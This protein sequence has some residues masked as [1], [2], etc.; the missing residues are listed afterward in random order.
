MIVLQEK[1][2]YIEYTS[3]GDRYEHLSPKEYLKA[4]R[5]Y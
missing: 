2:N 5:P 4:I 1:N 3:K